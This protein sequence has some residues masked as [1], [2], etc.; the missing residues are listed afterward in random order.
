MFYSAQTLAQL[1]T[2][3]ESIDAKRKELAKA[4][5][6]RTYEVQRAKEFAEHGVTRRI[7][8]MACCVESVFEILPPERADGPT[9][10]ELVHAVVYIQAFTFNAFALLDNLAWIWVCERG[11]TKDSGGPISHTSVGLG[12]RCKIVRRSLPAD[13]RSHV[14]SLDNWFEHLE[15]FRHAL[16]HRIPLY[17]PPRVISEQNME[18]YG[19]LERRKAKARRRGNDTKY[20]EL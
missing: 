15:N 13:L 8:T 10:D 20:S 14:K 2:E 1:R 19:L 18:T 4:F 12:K 6:A 16:A 9:I 11:L 3:R 7:R 5:V 17:I